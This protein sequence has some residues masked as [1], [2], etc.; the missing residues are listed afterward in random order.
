[1]NFGRTKHFMVNLTLCS[2][3]IQRKNPRFLRQVRT[4]LKLLQSL[5]TQ[6]SIVFSFKYTILMFWNSKVDWNIQR[7]TRRASLIWINYIRNYILWSDILCLRLSFIA[8]T[9][10]SQGL[11]LTSTTASFKFITSTMVWFNDVNTRRML[12]QNVDLR[13]HNLITPVRS[14][15][16]HQLTSKHLKIES[17]F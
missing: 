9:T 7:E 10:A 4:R 11:I 5:Q 15:D 13:E 14:M 17:K 8:S 1:M 16:L 6:W 12:N 2:S 3:K